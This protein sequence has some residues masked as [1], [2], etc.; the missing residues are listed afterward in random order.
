M[1]I[2]VI[3]KLSFRNK[4]RQ[5][6]KQQYG[7]QN[8]DRKWSGLIQQCP[9]LGLAKGYRPEPRFESNRHQRSV[10]IHT[11]FSTTDAFLLIYMFY[12]C[13]LDGRSLVR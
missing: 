10:S 8:C 9:C 12:F 7:A 6:N 11:A 3:L 1:I 4:N 13:V 5:T 2:L